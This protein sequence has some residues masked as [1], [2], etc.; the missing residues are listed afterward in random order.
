MKVA[1]CALFAFVALGAALPADTSA[2]SDGHAVTITSLGGGISLMET[3]IQMN[4]PEDNTHPWAAVTGTAFQHVEGYPTI[5]QF[6]QSEE[7]VHTAQVEI[8]QDGAYEYVF[9]VR[10]HDQDTGKFVDLF[11]GDYTVRI[12]NVVH[13]TS[14]TA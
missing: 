8:D 3:A 5:I 13:S 1:C 2:E 12:F 7:F 4:I 9:R 11:M 14:H 10:N 6:Y